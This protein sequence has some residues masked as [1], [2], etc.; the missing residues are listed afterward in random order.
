M[1]IRIESD[2]RG[3]VIKPVA[4]L[5][6]AFDNYR[7]A[8]RGASYDPDMQ[9]YVANVEVLP[10][11]VSRLRSGRFEVQMAPD[12]FQLAHGNVTQ[13]HAHWEHARRRVEQAGQNLYPYQREGAIK[14]ASR[15]RH[16]LADEMGLGK[17]RQAI[18]ACYDHAPVMVISPSLVKGV[19]R[20]EFNALRPDFD[21]NIINGKG[22]FRW[23][24]RGEVVVMNYDILPEPPLGPCLVP[25]CKSRR[26]YRRVTCTTH[27]DKSPWQN[28]D[29]CLFCGLDVHEGLDCLELHLGE[30][31]PPGLIVIPDEAH[32]LKGLRS[33]RTRAFRSISNA[34]RM[35][36]GFVWLLTG[37]PLLNRPSELW[38]VLAA[39]D[40]ASEAFG[41]YDDY[42]KMYGGKKGHFGGYVFPKPKNGKLTVEPPDEAVEQLSQV[43]LRRMRRDVLPDLPDKSYDDIEVDLSPGL[44]EECDEFIEQAR[45][46]LSDPAFMEKVP[47][48][49]TSRL[50]K[51]LAVAKMPYVEQFV[52]EYEEADEP[53]IV[54]SAHR[55]PIDIFKHR[56]GWAVITG[57]VSSRDRFNIAEAFQAGKL[58]GIAGT[59]DAAGVGITL[60]RACHAL[61]VDVEWTPALNQQAED[62]LLRIGQKRPVQIH[63][64][65]G[66][67]R[68]ERR[69]AEL[70][71][72]KTNMITGL[73]DRAAARPR[74]TL[75]TS[76]SAL[77]GIEVVD[78]KQIERVVGIK[79]AKVEG[80]RG[81][82]TTIEQWAANA[83]KML[84]GQDADRA[85]R[86]ND[87]GF[88]RDDND[89]GHS[90]HAQLEMG[91][92][93]MQWKF[94]VNMCRKYWRQVGA[95]PT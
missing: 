16:L 51:A 42:A 84:V 75:D 23:P 50:R 8:C 58:R 24:R 35:R 64:L 92:N 36:N 77:D 43:M 10:D 11:I 48:T 81:P 72:I 13:L 2:P 63:R 7:A 57:D 54:F 17:T 27:R 65:V 86:R 70:C 83:L 15:R 33:K 74:V 19:W 56:E 28:P 14:L 46:A 6:Y 61:F 3:V 71:S 91:L 21:V 34:A 22:G 62:R 67:H 39:A 32:M 90:L 89:V 87:V 44:E 66:A 26:R 95:P 78:G 40:I 73:I 93:D 4:R 5:G 30:N 80:R 53:L 69:V 9:C 94:A 60:T 29:K 88:N 20:K 76:V 41:T 49:Q 31:A 85:R 47:F 25:G 38:E 52:E 12:V 79:N 59:I 55:D 37:T 18:Y 1:R 68:L 45:V 82:K